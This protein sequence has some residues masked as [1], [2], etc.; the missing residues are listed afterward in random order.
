MVLWINSIYLTLFKLCGG[1]LYY[2]KHLATINGYLNLWSNIIVTNAISA[3]RW[4]S[5]KGGLFYDALLQLSL[6]SHNHSACTCACNG[7]HKLMI[8]LWKPHFWLFITAYR[9][10]LPFLEI[11]SLWLCLQE[12]VTG[13]CP[14][15]LEFSWHPH[16]VSWSFR[17]L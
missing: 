2:N 14:E 7:H 9:R 16:T 11:Q 8:M 13:P 15:P 6:P 17:A 12:P 4:F 1:M 3:T 10:S 5:C